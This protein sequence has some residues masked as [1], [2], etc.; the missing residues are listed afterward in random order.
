MNKF[1]NKFFLT[2]DKFMPEMHL[3]QT[4]STYRACYVSTSLYFH[5]E[6]ENLAEESALW[7]KNH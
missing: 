4:G 1:I 7:L 3:K 5:I 2:E 6:N